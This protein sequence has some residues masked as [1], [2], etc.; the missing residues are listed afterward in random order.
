MPRFRIFFL[1]ILICL[2]C[3]GKMK[4]APPPPDSTFRS[5]QQKIFS[6]APDSVTLIPVYY[7]Q[8][9]DIQ[10]QL[11]QYC[12][13]AP[14]TVDSLLT[15]CLRCRARFDS[16]RTLVVQRMKK[17]D[18]VFHDEAVK[19]KLNGDSS[20][21]EDLLLRSLQYNPSFAPSSFELVSLLL[22]PNSAMKAG[23]YYSRFAPLID[24]TNGYYLNLFR[25]LA[26]QV[27]D[28]LVAQAQILVNS[29]LTFDALDGVQF[30]DDFQKHFPSPGSDGKINLARKQAHQGMYDSYIYM[31]QRALHSRKYELADQYFKVARDY[32]KQHAEFIP[33]EEAWKTGI[34]KA[35][36]PRTEPD[37]IKKPVVRKSVHSRWK[38][39]KKHGRT[40]YYKP[41]APV[42][43]APVLPKDT[44]VRFYLDRCLFF[45][46]QQDLW[47]A[48]SAFDSAF[49]VNH[50][51]KAMDDKRITDTVTRLVKPVLLDTTRS[52]YYL[53]WKNELALSGN[54]LQAATQWQQH[55]RLMEDPE[56]REALQELSQRI[57]EKECFNLSAAYE[58]EVNRAQSQFLRGR[59]LEGQDHLQEAEKILATDTICP[60]SDTL[61]RKVRKNY[62]G[63]IEWETHYKSYRQALSVKD[64]LTFVDSYTLM[65]V[66]IDT[67][68]LPSKGLA[69]KDLLP[70]V[71]QL[72]DQEV[73]VGYAGIM[74]ARD[75]LDDV[76][77]I[78]QSLPPGEPITQQIR[79]LCDETGR[80]MAVEDANN[81]SGYRKLQLKQAD[82]LLRLVKKSYIRHSKKLR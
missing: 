19:L 73:S 3:P 5:L 70:F 17:I 13:T 55:F 16:V 53:T 62:Q 6:I 58:T 63:L 28:N 26:E 60:L 66:A 45:L 81:H 75:R 43:K 79:E 54:I 59:Y 72:N 61:V 14:P 31:A 32:Q 11:D 64:Y 71:L 69:R 44:L 67:W 33:S 50:R 46:K 24:T 21:A 48:V 36:A 57:R 23:T 25:E 27:L 41:P 49:S 77:A 47:S 80:K 51:I 9:D 35:E 39:K 18:L 65:L 12:N 76:T 30:A 74:L 4:A 37:P 38:H 10:N 20:G 2:I 15:G 78:L 1:S 42:V 52:A 68:D 29:N 22:R 82:H 7:I 56:V 34:A 40:R 8:L